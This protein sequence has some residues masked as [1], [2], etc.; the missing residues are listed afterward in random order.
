TEYGNN[1]IVLWYIH[2]NY[3]ILSYIMITL[4]HIL[5]TVQSYGYTR[6]THHGGDRVIVASK[7]SL[8]D[9]SIR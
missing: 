7:L 6:L 2:H 3:T 9:K 1:T 4:Y 8:H 5:Y